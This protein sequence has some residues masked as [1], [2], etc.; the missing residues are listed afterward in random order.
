MQFKLVAGLQRPED[1]L[2]AQIFLT[3]LFTLKETKDSFWNHL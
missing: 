2:L 3:K 1:E